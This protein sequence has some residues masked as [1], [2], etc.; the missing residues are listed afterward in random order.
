[1][2]CR[3]GCGACCIAPSISSAIPGMLGGKPAGARCVQLTV[4]SRCGLFGR[5]ERPAVCVGLRPRRDMCGRSAE[6]AVANL[7]AMEAATRP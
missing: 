1:M 2:R 6:E 5:P 3:P 7:A 4:D